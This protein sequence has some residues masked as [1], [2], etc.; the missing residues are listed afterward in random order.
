MSYINMEGAMTNL[1][2]IHVLSIMQYK[3]EMSRFHLAYEV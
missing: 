2:G 3:E 1:R